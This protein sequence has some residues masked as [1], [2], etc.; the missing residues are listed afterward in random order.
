LPD[1][2]RL[3]LIVVTPAI[4]HRSSALLDHLARLSRLRSE[5]ALSPLGL[6]PRHL[7]A[8]TLLR[9]HHGSTQQAL[10]GQ[11]QIDRTNLVGLLNELEADGLIA[12]RRA[13]EDRRRHIVE[14]T[15]AGTT[16]LQ[17]AECALAAAE[18]E[19][20]GALDPDQRETL[21]QLLQQAT[22][23]HVVDCAAAADVAPASASA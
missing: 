23:G 5:A 10:A 19:T 20:L 8:L 4:T 12:R 17:Q 6:R 1:G 21:Y 14:I 13:A 11:L 2:S 7:V 3:F 9:D 15:E 18:N 16:R 22:A